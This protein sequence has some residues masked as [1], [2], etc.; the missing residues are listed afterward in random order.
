[1]AAN[2][3]LYPFPLMLFSFQVSQPGGPYKDYMPSAY[4]LGQRGST[5]R[6]FADFNLQATRI[7]KPI[8]SY[9]P[10]PYFVE[11]NDNAAQLAAKPPG[12]ETGS[13][14]TRDF[15]LTA[16]WGRSSKS[17][18]SEKTIL[19]SVPSQ[20][21]SLA[22]LQHADLT[23][24]DIGASIGHQP[25]N[26]AG[27]SYASPFVKRGLTAELRASHELK[28]FPDKSGTNPIYPTSYYDLSY[29][30]NAAL[31]DSYF[32]SSIPRSGP[33]VPENPTLV[34]F[35]PNDTS[36]DI[37]DA[38]GLAVAPLLFIDGGFNINSTDKT[39]WKAFLASAKHFEHAADTT[40]TTSTTDSTDAAFPRGLAQSSPSAVPPSGENADSFTGYRRLTDSQLDA[41]ADEM[42]KQVRLRGPFLSISHFV[43]RA[44]APITNQPAL[45]R[46]G[47]L[48]TAIDESGANIS[49][50]G[51]KNAFT[52]TNFKP[53]DDVVTLGWKDGAPRADFDGVKSVNRPGNADFAKS[54][55]D[56]NYGSV[57]SIYSDRE[58]LSD[59]ALKPE[60][61]F[62]STGI[63]GWVTQADVLQ[64]IGASITARS[65]TFRIRTFGEA[66]DANGKSTAKAYCEAVIQ[67]TPAYVDPSNPATA[68]DSVATPLSNINKTYGRQYQIV[69]FRWLSAQEI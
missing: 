67:R 25:G 32:F 37:K 30:L 23:G 14:F 24:D 50:Q 43:N 1:M 3:M 34:R 28:G 49:F 35:N 29:L 38:K 33:A 21:S 56:Q 65:D 45:S 2:E 20:F 16:R 5:L 18:G 46:S 44:L 36:S 9:N 63:P 48:Q 55:T 64:V 8:A 68:R 59:A 27:N 4:D 61:G 57:A 60:Q 54:S 11:S 40:S 52:G 7:R 10:P 15:G 12:G 69:S 26:A 47:A 62:R 66:L 51:K 19:F 13:A 41:L 39:A 22:Q 31:W 17:G 42:V 6:T 53:T 58:I